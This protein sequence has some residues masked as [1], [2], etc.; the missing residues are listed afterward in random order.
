[1]AV[2]PEMRPKSVRRGSRLGDAAGQGGIGCDAWDAMSATSIACAKPET[3]GL[4]SQI[5]H[6][7]PTTFGAGVWVCRDVSPLR[8][9]HAVARMAGLVAGASWW[10]SGSAVGDLLD[11]ASATAVNA[12]ACSRC[13]R[14]GTRCRRRVLLRLG[15]RRPWEVPSLRRCWDVSNSDCVRSRSPRHNRQA[16]M[17]A[18]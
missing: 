13:G 5:S 6:S 10:T 16:R 8:V 2:W 15:L 17:R 12:P 18:V 7:D 1:M 14:A 3:R 11:A 9:G 4:R